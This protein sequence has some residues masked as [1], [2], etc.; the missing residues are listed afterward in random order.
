MPRSNLYALAVQAVGCVVAITAS[1]VALV[2]IAA[3][4]AVPEDPAWGLIEASIYS[5]LAHAIIFIGALSEYG[6]VRWKL[7]GNRST[8]GDVRLLDVAWKKLAYTGSPA[9]VGF[10]SA[11]LAVI[12]ATYAVCFSDADKGVVFDVFFTALIAIS[13]YSAGGTIIHRILYRFGHPAHV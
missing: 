11:I 8:G 7:Q 9:A 10:S 6:Y 13:L 4:Y 5:L 12:I 3:P 2:E 1:A